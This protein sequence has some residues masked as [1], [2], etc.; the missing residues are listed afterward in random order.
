MI[1]FSVFNRIDASHDDC[2]GT[3]DLDVNKIMEL[4]GGVVDDWFL[5]KPSN[6]S[7]AD[8]SDNAGS[9]KLRLNITPSAS[10]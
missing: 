2:L 6:A 9:I 3:V 1:A 5:L 8:S 4:G 7:S 10:R